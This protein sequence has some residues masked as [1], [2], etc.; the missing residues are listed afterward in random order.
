MRKR[1]TRQHQIEDLSYNFV[2]KHVLDAF[3][4]FKR[5]I[6]REYGYD[7]EIETFNR[8]GEVESG[9]LFVQV[10]AS[11]HIKYSKKQNGYKLT[12]LTKKRFGVV[13]G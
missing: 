7:A 4:I 3:C 1:R 8:K 6:G 5:F 9:T 11:D 12:D 10:K 2:E 13:V